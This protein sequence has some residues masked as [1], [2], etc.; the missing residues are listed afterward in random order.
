MKQEKQSIVCEQIAKHLTEVCFGGNWTTVNLR[1]SLKDV[2]WQEA[3]TQVGSLNSIATIVNHLHYYVRSVTKVL[4]GEALDSKD[5]LSFQH[6][7]IQS[8]QD[9]NKFL[10]NCWRETE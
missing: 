2:T 4:Q 7:P 8:E 5:E 10:D 3:V 1:E 9:W 6:P